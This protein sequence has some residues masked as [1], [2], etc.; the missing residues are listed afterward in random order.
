MYSA[1]IN[2]HAHEQN[3][4]TFKAISDTLCAYLKNGQIIGDQWHIIFYEPYYE[5]IVFL[6]EINS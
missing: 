5:T 1:L 4:E 6:P 3:E 2:F